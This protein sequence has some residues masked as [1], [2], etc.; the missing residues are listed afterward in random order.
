M[1][2]IIFKK[3]FD[4]FECFSI[5]K[6]NLLII[7]TT[8]QYFFIFIK[9]NSIYLFVCPY[10]V[11]IS[12]NVCIFHNLIVLSAD[13]LAKIV[14][15]LLN[16]TDFTA[17]LCAF[18]NAISELNSVSNNYIVPSFDPLAKIVPSLLKE[19]EFTVL[20][21]FGHVPISF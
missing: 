21:F 16:A 11:A 10:N 5:S 7:W 4:F 12:S 2:W 14:A 19:S 3:F 18:N 15:S 6:L 8:S 9:A 20:R 13:E 1:N 17:Y